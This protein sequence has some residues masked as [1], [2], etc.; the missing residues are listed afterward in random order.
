MWAFINIYK[1]R[2]AGVNVL[3]AILLGFVQ[4][5]T[6]FLPVSSSGHLILLEHVFGIS[7]GNLFFNVLLHFASLVA[8]VFLMRK[9]I[10]ELMKRPFSKQVK[11]IVVSCF[12]TAISVLLLEKVFDKFTSSSYL[13]FGFLLSAYLLLITHF[14]SK[15]Q[16]TIKKQEIGYLDACLI[17][18]CQGVSVLPG[19]SRSGTTISTALLLNNNKEKS[20]EFSFLISIPTIFGAMIYEIIK[21]GGKI[22]F[23]VSAMSYILGFLVS[24]VVAILSIK[25]MINIIKK[26]RWLIFSVYLFCLSLIVILN[27]YVFIWF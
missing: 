15:K 4:G 11:T 26:G 3:E 16:R 1:R 7:E 18:V 21:D 6:E 12:I 10:L 25:W 20:A 23:H 17:G 9:Q 27:Q 14:Y 8:V 2:K 5:L 24:F 19:V 13:G 22:D